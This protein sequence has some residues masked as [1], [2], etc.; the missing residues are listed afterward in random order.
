[1]TLAM[2][3]GLDARSV[4]AAWLFARNTPML[5]SRLLLPVLLVVSI[6]GCATPGREP[7]ADF[8]ALV[9]DFEAF[10][11]ERNPISAGRRGDLEAA[12]RWPDPSPEAVSARREAN[13]TFHARLQAIDAAALDDNRQV[14]YAVLG[15][16]LGS[17]VELAA[18]DPERL[19]FT[20]DSG[21]FSTPVSLALS[22]RPVNTGEAEAWIRRL[23]TLPDFFAAHVA[24]LRHGLETGWVQ[25]EP[26]V[27]AVLQQIEEIAATPAAEHMLFAP[28]LAL[29]AR[30]PEAERVRL[31]EAGLTAIEQHALPAYARLADFLRDTY[32]AHPREGVGISAVPGGRDY[33]RALVRYHTTLDTTPEEIHRIGLNEVAR[34]RAEMAA[35]IGESGFEGSFSEFLDYLRTDPKFY[36]RSEE[37]LLMRAAWLAKRA[38]DAMPRFF[39]NLPRLPYGVRP[40]PAALAP[41]YTTGRYWPGDLEAGIAGGYMVNTYALDQRPLYELPALTVHEGVPG[42]HHQVAIAQELVDVPEFRRQSYITAYGEGWGLYTE[43]LAIEMG[44][45]DTP[46]DH[47][48]RLTFEMWRACR[49]VVDTGLHYFGWTV[50]EA[51]ACLLE[52]SALAPHNVRTEIARYVSWPGQA[53]AYKTGELLIRDLRAEAEAALGERFDLRAFHDHILSDGAMPLSALQARMQAWMV[54]QQGGQ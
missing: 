25:P 15:Y 36:A 24:W 13:A 2:A 23:E 4:Y 42:H 44:L 19:P 48:G 6:V 3:A 21:F 38:D 54:A 27:S 47:F 22:T 11:L 1:M 14:S 41:N 39:R 30:M 50:A 28:L 43:Y 34:I 26:I 33:Y 7:S 10:E 17:A 40:V 46:Y 12:G 29:P 49:L 37:E 8:D 32:L 31:R 35:V 9:A 51:E 18:F 16:R 45:Y 52:N 53:L 20:N 5:S